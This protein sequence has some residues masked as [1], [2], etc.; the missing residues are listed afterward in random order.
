MGRL[1]DVSLKV[2]PGMLIYPGDPDVSIERVSN[3]DAGDPSNVSVFSM[4]THTGT[5]VD[6]PAHFVRDGA[7]I[8]ELPLDTFVG[9]AYVVD[10][11]GAADIDANA[12]DAAGIPGGIE[13]LLFLTDW[14]AR[15][16]LDPAPSFPD[17][18]TAM[19]EDGAEWLISHGIRLVGTDFL[20]I[21]GAGDPAFPVHRALLG[22][23]IAVVEGL[24][25]REVPPGSC[26]FVCL[27]LKLRAGDGG[28]ARAF[29][30]TA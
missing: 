13:R 23:E 7:T 4:S 27:P 3:M 12:L 5:H 28:P 24:D 20:S 1:I 17:T 19:T 29:V 16:G 30:E 8:D 11:R 18:Y 10:V 21:E 6:P 2:G 9:P 14:S 25:L 26:R 15:W 22:A